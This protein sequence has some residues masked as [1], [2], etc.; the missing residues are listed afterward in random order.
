M[1][2]SHLLEHNLL[3]CEPEDPQSIQ[4]ASG[5]DFLNVKGVGVQFNVMV[6]WR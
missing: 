4:S 3:T 6:K 2:V 5:L 1:A